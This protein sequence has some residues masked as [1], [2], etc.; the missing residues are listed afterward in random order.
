[1][2]LIFHDLALILLLCVLLAS[3]ETLQGI[4]RAAV[5]VPRLGKKTALKISAITGS[6]LAL[7][8]CSW[9]IPKTSLNSAAGLLLAGVILA[10]F[11]AL[12]DVLIG[13]RVMK[14]SWEKIGRDFNP[15]NGNYLS[16][17]LLLLITYPWVVMQ[18]LG[19]VDTQ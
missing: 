17:A 1:M 18:I 3:A 5:L 7:L 15:A 6:L 8:L 14:L 10:A 2:T 4:V 11:M 19:P 13:R 12:F 9:M 16:I